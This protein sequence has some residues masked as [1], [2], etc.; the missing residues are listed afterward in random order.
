MSRLLWG[1]PL[2][3]LLFITVVLLGFSFCPAFLEPNPKWPPPEYD[4]KIADPWL[5]MNTVPLNEDTESH[6]AKLTP[7][8]FVPLVCHL[9]GLDAVGAVALASLANIGTLWLIWWFCRQRG[10]LDLATSA[11]SVAAAGSIYAGCMGFLDMRSYPFDGVAVFLLTLAAVCLGRHYWALGIAFFLALWTDERALLTLPVYAVLLDPGRRAASPGRY[12]W[13]A[14]SLGVA[15][16]GYAILRLIL[17][18]SLGW[19][20]NFDQVGIGTMIHNL[21]LIPLGVALLFEGWWILIVPALYRAIWVRRHPVTILATLGV[22]LSLAASFM[23]LDISRSTAFLFPLIL[24]GIRDLADLDEAARMRL[25]LGVLAACIATGTYTLIGAF[26]T[27]LRL[28]FSLEW[29]LY[30]LKPAG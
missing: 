20:Q 25:M 5:D 24:I 18:L 15:V 22:T 2:R 30:V 10:G 14:I 16:A 8:I 19:T 13:S 21:N 4:Q 26:Y 17:T 27:I 11:L 12:L 7:R 23:V 3:C 29:A 1:S 28:P 9:L 6:S